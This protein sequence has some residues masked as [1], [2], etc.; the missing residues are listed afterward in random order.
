MNKYNRLLIIKNKGSAAALAK[1]TA[2]LLKPA[3][4][5]NSV[6]WSPANGSL[7]DFQYIKCKWLFELL[8]GSFTSIHKEYGLISSFASAGCKHPRGQSFNTQFLFNDNGSYR[9]VGSVKIRGAWHLLLGHFF[10]F[11]SLFFQGHGRV[12]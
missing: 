8:T 3:G 11:Y 4:A 12:V 7:N 5:K 9:P 2:A 6:Y 10:R 1:A